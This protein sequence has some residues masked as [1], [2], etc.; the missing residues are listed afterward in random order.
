M[1]TKL[2]IDREL[3]EACDR[4]NSPPPLW[5][6]EKIR[7][8]LSAPRQPEG[9]G[10]EVVGAAAISDDGT[11][12]DL[13][14]EHHI[15]RHWD[16][17]ASYRVEP[18]CRLSDAQRAI[19]ELRAE[20]DTWKCISKEAHDHHSASMI[21]LARI[22]GGDVS[23]EPRL[24]WVCGIAIDVITERETLRQQLAERDADAERWRYYAPEVARRCGATLEEMNATVDAALAEVNKP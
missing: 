1:T 14:T 6:V 18:L 4:R 15:R 5:A 23:D 17:H 24:K 11:V 2:L 7:A 10:L 12:L 9:E 22:L 3:L 13:N 8:I 19:A 21:E 20:V 16:G